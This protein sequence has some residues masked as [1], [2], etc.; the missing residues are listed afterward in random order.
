[1]KEARYSKYYVAGEPILHNTSFDQVFDAKNSGYES[2]Q[3]PPE[4]KV[5]ESIVVPKRS[6]TAGRQRPMIV[7]EEL[8][9]TESRETI[10]NFL[11]E[12]YE[13]YSS[14]MTKQNVTQTGQVCFHNEQINQTTKCTSSNP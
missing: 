10:Y 5:E 1:M 13:W 9:I 4:T 11:R 7:R 2:I 12:E 14:L 6:T 3:N 8:K